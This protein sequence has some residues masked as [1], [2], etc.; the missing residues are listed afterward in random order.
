MTDTY[1]DGGWTGPTWA[2]A[3]AAPT[4]RWSVGRAIVGAVAEKDPGQPWSEQEVK[5][6]IWAVEE[7]ARRLDTELLLVLSGLGV[8]AVTML[9]VSG[10]MW[11][12]R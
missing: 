3:S 9:V 2:R 6:R 10:S 7:K 1:L 5:E 11:R 8:V 4:P 12:N